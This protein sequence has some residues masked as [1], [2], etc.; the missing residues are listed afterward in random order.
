MIVVFA[1]SSVTARTKETHVVRDMYPAEMF[2]LY[3][4]Y[5]KNHAPCQFLLFFSL[6][7]RASCLDSTKS[8]NQRSSDLAHR[9][10][11]SK[12]PPPPQPVQ[13]TAIAVTK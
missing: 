5:C 12:L 13:F 7:S 2:V 3:L 10:F 4:F 11:R 6:V 8:A 9:T 1:V